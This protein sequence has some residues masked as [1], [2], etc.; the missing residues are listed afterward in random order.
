[1]IADNQQA[2][3]EANQAAIDD[4]N[5][6]MSAEDT[7]WARKR[8]N[9]KRAYEESKEAKTQRETTTEEFLFRDPRGKEILQRRLGGGPGILAPRAFQALSESKI[10]ST[11]DEVQA[12][13]AKDLAKN[14]MIAKPGEAGAKATTFQS[15]AGVNAVVGMGNNAAMQAM[16]DQLEEQRKQTALL[17]QIASS[18]GDLPADFTKPTS[19]APSRSAYLRK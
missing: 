9:E 15:P 6:L 14:G 13:L 2:R 1:M 7:Y 3:A 16:L 4:T 18:G 8:N 19:A 5:K 10:K 12:I 17:Q 11:Q